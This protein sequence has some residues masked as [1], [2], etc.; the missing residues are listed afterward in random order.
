MENVPISATAQISAIAI[1]S[2]CRHLSLLLNQ[3]LYQQYLGEGDGHILLSSLTDSCVQVNRIVVE[4][5]LHTIVLSYTSL[6]PEP[7]ELRIPHYKPCVPLQVWRD[8]VA[9]NLVFANC[10]TMLFIA[11]QTDAA[12]WKIVC[13]LFTLCTD[14][15]FCFSSWH[16]GFWL[17]H[18]TG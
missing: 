16:P 18:S 1:S 15:H 3:W 7:C 17:C 2:D 5:D 6:Q 11:P 9:T 10:S 13:R 4:V 12:L 8:M 14:E